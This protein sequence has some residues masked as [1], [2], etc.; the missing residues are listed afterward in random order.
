MENDSVADP[1]IDPDPEKAVSLYL[2]T[3]I[4]YRF[5]IRLEGKDWIQPGKDQ[6]SCKLIV[7]GEGGLIWPA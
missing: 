5:H 3:R 6:D 4:W 2:S 1:A 7:C